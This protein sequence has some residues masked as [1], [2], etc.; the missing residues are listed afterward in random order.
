MASYESIIRTIGQKFSDGLV[1][2]TQH[3][4]DRSILRR[5]SLNE[6][7]QAIASGEVI[8]DYPDDK[9]GP[10]CLIS[11]YILERRPLHVQ[12][13][14]PTRPMVK[15]ITVY[16]PDPTLW[17]DFKTRRSSNGL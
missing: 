5:I 16:Q 3:A 4:T 17:T 13:S 1:E 15:V 14:Y 12:C 6:I 8:E 7:R 11:G 9:Y 10:S 2:F